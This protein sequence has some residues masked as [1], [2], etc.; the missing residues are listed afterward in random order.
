MPEGRTSLLRHPVTLSSVV[1]VLTIC[2]AILPTVGILASPWIKAYVVTSAAS[3][4]AD[5][6]ERQTAPSTAAAKFSLQDKID[7]LETRRT[8]LESQQLRDPSKFTDAMASEL[9][10]VRA[11][12]EKARAA[13]ADFERKSRDKN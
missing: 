4:I 13:L 2:G 10:G 9:A 7:E 12:L 11:R 1:S 3:E 6:V 8:I 5:Q